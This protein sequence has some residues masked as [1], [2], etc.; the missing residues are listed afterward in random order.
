[1]SLQFI[2]GGSGSGKS[3]KLYQNIIHASMQSPETRFLVIVPEQFTMQTQRE[4]VRLH[5]KHG[6]WNIDILSFQR[7]AH[8]IFEEVG[9]DRR[10][11]LEETGKTLLLRRA[12]TKEQDHLKVLKGNLKKRGYLL[13]VKSMISELTQYDIDREKMEELL[14]TAEGRPQLYYKLQDISILYEAFRREQEGKYITAEETLDALCQVADQSQ[15]L[16]GAVIALDGFT[17]FTP[18]QQK[19]LRRL[20]GLA[21]EVTVTVTMDASADFSRIRGPHELFYLSKKMI[22]SLTQMAREVDCELLSPI[23]LGREG[24]PRFTDSPMLAQLEKQIFRG[25]HGLR[26]PRLPEEGGHISLHISGN[27]VEEAH[28]AARS[29]RRFIQQGHRYQEIAVIVGDIASYADHIPRVFAQYEIPFFMDHT[30]NVFTNPMVELLRALLE[31]AEQDYSRSSVFRCLRTGL[32]DMARQDVDI[33]ENYVLAHGVRGA[34]GWKKPFDRGTASLTE[35]ELLR[36]EELR[37]QWTQSVLDPVKI[38]RSVRTTARQKTEALYGLLC[39]YQVQNALA[40]YEE[41]FRAAGEEALS[42]EYAQVY[43]MVLGLFDKIV[44]LLG[45]ETLDLKEYS[46]LMEAGLEELKIGIIPPTLDCV[47]VG[48]LERTRLQHVSA[49]FV[50][51]LNDGWVPRLGNSGGLLNDMERE[52]LDT[53]TVTLA[54]TVR[55]DSYIQKFYLYMNLTKPSQ[56]LYLSCCKAMCDGTQ[57]RPSYVMRTVQRIFPEL[58]VRDEEQTE[59]LT[60]RVMTGANGLTYITGGLRSL[61]EQGVSPEWLEL[62][63]WYLQ[64][65]EYQSAVEKLTDAAFMTFDERG[66][67]QK[68]ARELYGSTLRGSV[69]RLERF[70]ACAFAHFLQY[71][72]RIGEREEYQFRPADMGN[73]FHGA[74]ESFAQKV[75]ES[76]YDWKSLPHTERER[77]V[78]ECLEQ[79]AQEQAGELLHGSA[80]NEAA[81]GRMRRILQRTAWA[82]QRQIQAGNFRPSGFEIAFSQVEDLSAVN[83][84]LSSEEKMK[85]HGRIDRIDVHESEDRVLVKVI[86][87]KSGNAR[88]DLTALYHGLQLQ[89]IVYLDA[90]MELEKR[91]HKDKEVVPAGIFYYHMQDPLLEE[92]EDTEAQEELLLRELRPNGLVNDRPEIFREMDTQLQK[93]SDVIPLS[94]NKDGTPSKRGSGAVTTEQFHQLTSF[95]HRKMTETGRRIMEGEIAPIPYERGGRTGCDYCIYRSICRLDRRIPGTG[96]HRLKEYP[97]EELWRRIAGQG[98]EESHGDGMDEGT[99]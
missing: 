22:H 5:P 59:H 54:P 46:E 65:P 35:E 25:G 45:E 4:L 49:L 47:Q 38:L 82:L 77:L 53:S 60:E 9:A 3:C 78:N 39:R 18:I 62:Y 32:C 92:A 7:L 93:T 76:P 31:M 85:L 80:R 88:F 56:R 87:Y 86:D 29:I 51:G 81:L 12:A 43:G 8:R 89:L 40:Q 99:A 16:K 57:M 97:Q 19:L 42:R 6:I 10:V 72:L 75:S 2:I 24:F 21:K 30:R 95:V 79:T 70:S 37:Q 64:S 73:I 61:N 1:M 28:F 41:R 33:L 74:L 52:F 36:C 68:A 67:G 94:L 13:Q 58:E 17:G 34:S 50:L 27:P 84:S 11:V 71:G 44:E 63:R 91:I 83:L 96:V 20:L 66:I 14:E 98:E 90:A 26:M 15:I 69:S 23:C 55:E 48:D